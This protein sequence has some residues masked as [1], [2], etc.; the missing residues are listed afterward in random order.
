M[1]DNC[2]GGIPKNFAL[3]SRGTLGTGTGQ[4]QSMFLM[5]V[6]EACNANATANLR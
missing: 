6:I 2:R 4:R 3:R 1:L 5:N